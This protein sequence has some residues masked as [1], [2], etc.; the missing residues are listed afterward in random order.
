MVEVAYVHERRKRPAVVL[1]NFDEQTRLGM[2][3]RRATDPSIPDPVNNVRL[4]YEWMILRGC[5]KGLF[6]DNP[7]ENLE[8]AEQPLQFLAEQ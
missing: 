1:S 8:V 4:P 3:I 5:A 2:P 6:D 7:I